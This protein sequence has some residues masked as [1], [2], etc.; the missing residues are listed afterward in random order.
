MRQG[1]S[2]LPQLVIGAGFAQAKVISHTVT[3]TQNDLR[4][5]HHDEL[6][7]REGYK[8]LFD[9]TPLDSKSPD[10]GKGYNNKKRVSKEHKRKTRKIAKQ[11][12]QTNRRMK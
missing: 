10:P 5:G 7:V 6:F 9:L 11:S 3:I 12:R 4:Y 2:I 8:E 1:K